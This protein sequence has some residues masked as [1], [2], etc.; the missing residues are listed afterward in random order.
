MIIF[1]SLAGLSLLCA[2]L[3]CF[4]L[5][6]AKCKEAIESDS[7][8]YQQSWSTLDPS[9]PVYFVQSTEN[10]HTLTE[11]VVDDTNQLDERGRISSGLGLEKQCIDKASSTGERISEESEI[12]IKLKNAGS[13]RTSQTW[14]LYDDVSESSEKFQRVSNDREI[15]YNRFQRR[16]GRLSLIPVERPGIE[17]MQ[18]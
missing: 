1:S 11:K 17:S 8:P 15:R 12:A 7:K 14:T 3:K 9:A 13:S 16:P 10:A 4:C 5:G 18:F 6:L 2:F